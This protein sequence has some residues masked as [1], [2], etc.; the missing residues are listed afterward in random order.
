[1]IVALFGASQNTRY[2]WIYQ[3]DSKVANRDSPGTEVI[4]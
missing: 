2:Q 4:N 3:M 1:M